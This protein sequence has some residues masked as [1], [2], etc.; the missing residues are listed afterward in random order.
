MIEGQ[1]LEGFIKAL[2]K[3]KP[4]QKVYHPVKDQ[5]DAIAIKSLIP[6]NLRQFAGIT[7]TEVHTLEQETWAVVSRAGTVVG[8]F[9]SL[10][11]AQ[12]WADDKWPPM[13]QG[14]RIV[15]QRIQDPS[16]PL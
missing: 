3:C 13:M 12:A 5:A 8:P 7:W 11:K 14:K 2:K 15:P 1:D 4:G 9:P 10:E 16:W 6:T